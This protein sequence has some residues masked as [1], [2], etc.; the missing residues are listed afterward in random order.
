M[1]SVS[2]EPNFKKFSPCSKYL[3]VDCRS[4]PTFLMAQREVAMATTFRVKNGKIGLFTFIR[5][6]DI[7]KR[8]AISLF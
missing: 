1:I 2:T 4:D 6:P 3:I 8:I 5:S 7:P